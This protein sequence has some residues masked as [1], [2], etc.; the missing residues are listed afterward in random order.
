MLPSRSRSSD[1]HCGFTLIELLI[2]VVI[3]GILASIAYPSF[4]DSLR[5]SRRSD[6]VAGL[7]RVQHAQERF[8]ANNAAYSLVLNAFVPP[9]PATS[10]DGHYAIAVTAANTVGYTA[11]ATVVA[12]SPQAAD[13]KC[14]VLKIRLNDLNGFVQRSSFDAGG[15]ENSSP[16]NPCWVK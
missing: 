1:R 16:G 9:V 3:V 2:T 8:R 6:A 15:V 10:P 5:K 11:T 7:T 12:G 14:Q 13:S 4:M